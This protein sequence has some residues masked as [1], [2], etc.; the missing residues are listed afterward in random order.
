MWVRTLRKLESP[1]SIN[2]AL[3]ITRSFICRSHCPCNHHFQ[4]RFTQTPLESFLK[5]DFRSYSQN[6]CNRVSKAG[7]QEIAGSKCSP[8]DSKCNCQFMSSQVGP[9]G[10]SQLYLVEKGTQI[11]NFYIPSGTAYKRCGFSSRSSKVSLLC[12]KSL[13]IVNRFAFG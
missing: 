13:L 11:Q 8:G 6:Y 2:P 7:A 5:T 10:G 3:L 1:E 9:T 4:T 12:Y